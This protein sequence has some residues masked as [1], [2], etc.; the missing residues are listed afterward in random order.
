MATFVTLFAGML[1]Q[2]LSRLGLGARSAFSHLSLPQWL[3]VAGA[4]FFVVGEGVLV[5]PK[6]GIALGGG[7]S[8][9]K[10]EIDTRGLPAQGTFHYTTQMTLYS[11][12]VLATVFLTASAVMAR[13]RT[14]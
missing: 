6:V 10:E 8:V 11:L 5:C 12:H 2:A 13:H 4:V 1:A 7:D 9:Q 14:P 3:G